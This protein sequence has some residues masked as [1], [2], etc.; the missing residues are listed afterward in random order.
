MIGIPALGEQ[1]IIRGMI[2]VNRIVASLGTNDFAAHQICMNFESDNDKRREHRN[3]R[4]HAYGTEHRK[5]ARYGA[6]LHQPVPENRSCIRLCSE[7]IV[8][9]SGIR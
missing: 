3:L 9:I 6:G 4:H 1:V 7:D 8:Y 5:T 2:A